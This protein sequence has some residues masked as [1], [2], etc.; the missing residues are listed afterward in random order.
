MF[1]G[2]AIGLL[3]LATPG[4]QSAWLGPYVSP[5]VTGRVVV[6]DSLEP[7][8][9]VR[10]LRGPEANPSSR[11]YP[12]KGGE[13]LMRR[14]PPVTGRDGRF[15]LS[16]ERILA[17]GRWGG[18][19]SVRLAFECPG[20]RPYQTNYPS[21]SLTTTNDGDGTPW[22]DVGDIRLVSRNRILP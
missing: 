21:T 2:L 14:P 20:Y 1:R 13:L 5:R 19:S 6:A 11:A 10:V 17:L 22:L 15:A 9:G 18:W 8:A 3:V 7:L 4:C 12:P 16:S